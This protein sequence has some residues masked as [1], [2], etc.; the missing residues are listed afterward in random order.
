MMNNIFHHIR[1]NNEQIS[2]MSDHDLLFLSTS[3]H[4]VI[5]SITNG[6]KSITNLAGAAVN[7]AEY[8]HDEAI[9]D[10]D[11]LSRLFSVLPHIIEA[12]YENNVNAVSELRER[13]SKTQ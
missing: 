11:R 13:R 9:I 8:S 6:M 5:Y 2:E 1:F 7:S 10:L 3:S 4:E 12:E